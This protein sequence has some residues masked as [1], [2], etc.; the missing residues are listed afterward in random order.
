MNFSPFDFDFFRVAAF[1]ATETQLKL[2][3]VGYSKTAV[4]CRTYTLSFTML[5]DY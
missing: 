5:I 2:E 1:A 4:N 3:P